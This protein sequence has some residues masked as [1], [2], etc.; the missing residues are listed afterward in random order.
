MRSFINLVD[1]PTLSSPNPR[2]RGVARRE[3]PFRVFAQ[4]I[5]S[6][7]VRNLPNRDRLY[8]YRGPAQRQELAYLYTNTV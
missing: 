7:V 8:T 1:I 3:N 2:I 5:R 6:V 4:V